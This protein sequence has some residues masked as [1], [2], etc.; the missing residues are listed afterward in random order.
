MKNVLFQIV[1]LFILTASSYSQIPD[2]LKYK[3]LEPYDFH[4]TWLK[5]DPSILIDVREAFECKGKIIKG[6]VNIPSTGNLDSAADTIDKNCSLFLYCTTGYRSKRA[7]IF[8]YSKG[9]RK[10]YSLDGGLVAWKD[11]G[12]PVVKGRG[13]R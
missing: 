1:L 5:T 4:L 9:F 2:S 11:E 13:K 7:A 10:L 3:S 8:L 6:S 12:F